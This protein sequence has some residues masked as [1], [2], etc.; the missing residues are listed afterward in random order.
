[1]AETYQ[2]EVERG[3]AFLDKAR[4]GWD[5]RVALPSLI[6][7]MGVIVWWGSLTASMTKVT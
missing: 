3:M 6:Y 5:R 1:M 2:R 4:P 7:K